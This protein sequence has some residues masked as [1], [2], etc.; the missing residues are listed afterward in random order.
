MNVALWMSVGPTTLPVSLTRHC[1]IRAFSESED[2]L[3]TLLGSPG[4]RS[5]HLGIKGPVQGVVTCDSAG[6]TNVSN[7]RVRTRRSV[8]ARHG[9]KRL[10]TWCNTVVRTGNKRDIERMKQTQADARLCPVMT[11]TPR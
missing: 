11:P 5:R 4:Y 8:G 9:L 2:G 7:L 1:A 6:C 10:G 3:V